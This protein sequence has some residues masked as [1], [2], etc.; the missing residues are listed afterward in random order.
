MVEIITIHG[1][2]WPRVAVS[3]PPNKGSISSRHVAFFWEPEN[4]KTISIGGKMTHVLVYYE[5]IITGD[6]STDPSFLVKLF[7]NHSLVWID[8]LKKS[9]QKNARKIT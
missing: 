3:L 1:P 4:Q 7:R 6:S 8:L 2:F 5:D 9:H